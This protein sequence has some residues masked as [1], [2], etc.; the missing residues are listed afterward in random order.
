MGQKIS[1][2]SLRLGVNTLWDSSWCCSQGYYSNSLKT[3]LEIR[4]FLNAILLKRGILP[5]KIS[6]KKSCY[7]LI[8]DIVASPLFDCYQ[9][10]SENALGFEKFLNDG[11]SRD[12]SSSIYTQGLHKT[13]TLITDFEKD[14]I[15]VNI[16]L[17]SENSDS[18]TNENYTTDGHSPL[19]VITQ[20]LNPSSN[21][22]TNYIIKQIEYSRKQKDNI[23]KKGSLKRSI[24]LVAS[25][26]HEKFDSIRGIRIVCSGRINGAERS[27]S[28]SST[29]GAILL[30]TISSRVDFHKS[31]ARTMYGS[32]GVKVWICFY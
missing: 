17:D 5:N 10:K 16:I 8:I 15:F 14:N 3:D 6:I 12:F 21:L 30:H 2:L 24:A 27:Q 18:L 25:T 28:V 32:I 20:K 4:R 31:H 13:L 26:V 29:C 9:T 11:S 7:S 22:I 19:R 1:A 23:F